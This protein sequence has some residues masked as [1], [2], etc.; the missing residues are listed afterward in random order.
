MTWEWWVLLVALVIFLVLPA[1]LL[2]W[3]YYI[4]ADLDGMDDDSSLGSQDVDQLY[5]RLKDQ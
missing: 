4:G 3:A 1:G 5:K 2:L